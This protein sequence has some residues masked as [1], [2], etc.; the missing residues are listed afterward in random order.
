MAR[1]VSEDE[2][3]WGISRNWR[4]AATVVP[5]AGALLVASTLVHR[6]LFRWVTHEDGPIEWAQFAFD[7]VA[8]VGAAIVAVLL[9]RSGR[10]WSALL[11]V[12]FA[13]SQFFI[14]GEEISWGQRILHTQTPAELSKLNHQDETNVHDIRP[15]QDSI[16][17]V[18]M[19]VGAYGSLGT[20]ALRRRLDR[21]SRPGW[22]ELFVPPPSLVTLFALVFSYKLLR[23]AVFQSPRFVIVK[24]GEYIEL[25]TAVALAA[26]AWLTVRRLRRSAEPE[27]S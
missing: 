20:I 1:L 13:L 12:V 16:N 19:V 4:V 25:C 24:F 14:A 23:L 15:I 18:F 17:V 22:F 11:W 27:A 21:S 2:Q 8:S 3:I 9:V 6:P 5:I 10:R 7:L 26:F